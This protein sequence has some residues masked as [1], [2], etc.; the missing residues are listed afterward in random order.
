MM[1]SVVVFARLFLLPPL[2]LLHFLPPPHPLSLSSPSPPQS[3]NASLEDVVKQLTEQLEV[4]K[5]EKS[6]AKGSQTL[7]REMERLRE[8][9]SS[10]AKALMEA[11]REREELTRELEL[12]KAQVIRVQVPGIKINIT[13]VKLT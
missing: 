8:E 13:L 11:T 9:N 1:C 2:F 3:L 5:Q 10:Q 6:T 7:Q 12:M 4:T